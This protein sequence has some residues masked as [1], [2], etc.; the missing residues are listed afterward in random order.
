VFK[1][2]NRIDGQL[3]IYDVS[4]KQL[5]T[6]WIENSAYQTY[7]IPSTGVYLVSFENNEINSNT[8]V[9]IQ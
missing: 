4:G 3:S 2:N 7:A 1:S 8:K 5:F 9:L 6:E